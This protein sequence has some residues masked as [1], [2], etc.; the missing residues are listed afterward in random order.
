V[1]G[2]AIGGEKLVDGL[3]VEVERGRDIAHAEV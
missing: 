2:G 1:G 3:G